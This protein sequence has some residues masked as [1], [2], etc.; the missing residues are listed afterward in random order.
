M[1]IISII[2]IKFHLNG[3]NL[4]GNFEYNFFSSEVTKLKHENYVM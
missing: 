2:P 3:N 1:I 4:D